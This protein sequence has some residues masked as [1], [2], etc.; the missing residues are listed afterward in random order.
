MTGDAPLHV[1]SVEQFALSGS[2]ARNGVLLS[3]SNLLILTD[4]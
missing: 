2:T 4:D 1:E 3:R